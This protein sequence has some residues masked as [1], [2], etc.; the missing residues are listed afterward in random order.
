M[1][2]LEA[3]LHL[4][5]EAVAATKVREFGPVNGHGPFAVLEVGEL[6]IYLRGDRAAGTLRGVARQL[7][8]HFDDPAPRG[9]FTNVIAVEFSE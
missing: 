7:R 6:R 2:H 5:A 8:E 1:S 9:P 4:Q 3:T